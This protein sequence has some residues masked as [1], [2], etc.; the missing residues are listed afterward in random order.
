MKRESA[1][2]ATALSG[3]VRRWDCEKVTELGGELDGKGM[4]PYANTIKDLVLLPNVLCNPLPGHQLRHLELPDVCDGDLGWAAKSSTTQTQVSKL[5]MVLQSTQNAKP[6]TKIQNHPAL[7]LM[8]MPT[9]TGPATGNLVNIGGWGGGGRF[10]EGMGGWR[11]FCPGG[12]GGEAPPNSGV[13][14]PGAIRQF[15]RPPA[16]TESREPISVRGAAPWS[17]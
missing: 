5:D 12:G 14:G 11:G 7:K 4:A 2:S 17:N 10:W 9:S 8:H 15:A 1:L 13:G 6:R 3:P 16:P